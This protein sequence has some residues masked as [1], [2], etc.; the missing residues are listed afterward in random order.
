MTFFRGGSWTKFEK[1]GGVRQYRGVFMN[2]GIRT[3][4]NMDYI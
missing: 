2:K 3:P 1:K 4:A